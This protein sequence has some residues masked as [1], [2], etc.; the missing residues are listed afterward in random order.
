[1]RKVRGMY[2]MGWWK[3]WIGQRSTDS[4]KAKQ[5]S[6]NGGCDAGKG[7]FLFLVARKGREEPA[8]CVL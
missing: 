3:E 1:M 7:F 5:L 8:N 4:N 6:A 2:V